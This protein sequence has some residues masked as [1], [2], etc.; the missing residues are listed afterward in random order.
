[1]NEPFKG[2]NLSSEDRRGN[3]WHQESSRCPNIALLD[4]TVTIDNSEPD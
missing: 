4:A 1:M 2:E 3:V